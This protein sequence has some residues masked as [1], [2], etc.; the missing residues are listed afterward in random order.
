MTRSA[1][2]ASRHQWRYPLYSIVLLILLNP[3]AIEASFRDPPFVPGEKL[4]YQLRWSVIPA[5]IAVLEVQP[6]ATINGTHACHFVL[7]ARSNSFVDVFYKVRDRID[8]YADLDMTHSLLYKKQQHEGKTRRKVVV[9]FDWNK[10]I[11]Q[12]SNF[13]KKEKSISV[14]P[15]TFD[16]LSVFFYLRLQ[17]LKTGTLVS[18]PV[19][20]G[21]KC[22]LG[23]AWIIKKEKVS[24]ASGTHEAFL[25]E[26]ELKHIGGVF[27]KSKNAKIQVWVSADRHCIP[28]K[29]ASEVVVGSF[30]GELVAVEGIRWP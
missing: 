18:R 27:E 9:D 26:P 1:V 25:V 30:V 10:Q 16:P 22:V 17:T 20:D 8:A 29:I 13:N 23:N 3:L 2:I 14:P 4:T 12:Y 21:K 6:A 7:T 5:G 24:L 28:L 15:G 11:V 19:T